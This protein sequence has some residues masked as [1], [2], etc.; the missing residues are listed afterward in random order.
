MTH[1][2][3]QHSPEQ[4]VKDPVCGMQIDVGSAFATVDRGGQTYYFCSQ[5]CRERFDAVL[6]QYTDSV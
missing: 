3:G 4:Q 5:H 1:N 2:Q 6:E